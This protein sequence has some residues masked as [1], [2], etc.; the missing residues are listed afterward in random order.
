MF[1]KNID[2]SELSF[3]KAEIIGDKTE[4]ELERNVRLACSSSQQ[5]QKIVCL[6][7][8]QIVKMD[9]ENI[10]TKINTF[11]SSNNKS[12]TIELLKKYNYKTEGYE[13]WNFV[14]PSDISYKSY[15]LSEDELKTAQQIVLVDG[16]QLCGE[17]IDIY[18]YS[19]I[20]TKTSPYI[21]K[22]ITM[23]TSLSPIPD[24]CDGGCDKF[25]TFVN[26]SWTVC[27][28]TKT[29][30]TM[31][32]RDTAIVSAMYE[33]FVNI[34]RD[35]SKFQLPNCLPENKDIITKELQD[36]ECRWDVFNKSNHNFMPKSYIL[37][38]VC[39]LVLIALL[40]R[41]HYFQKRDK[42]GFIK[43]KSFDKFY[44]VGNVTEIHGGSADVMCAWY[45]TGQ[46]PRLF[47]VEIQ[48]V[49]LKQY[50]DYPMGRVD[51]QNEATRIFCRQ[52]GVKLSDRRGGPMELL[53]NWQRMICCRF[54]AGRLE[55]EELDLK[56]TA[57]TAETTVPASTTARMNTHQTTMVVSSRD[58]ATYTMDKDVPSGDSFRESR[59]QR[60]ACHKFKNNYEL[61]KIKLMPTR[62]NEFK[63]EIRILSMV[64]GPTTVNAIGYYRKDGIVLVMEWY[65][66][67]L[68]NVLTREETKLKR[69]HYTEKLL[70]CMV[71]LQSKNP[72]ALDA[73]LSGGLLTTLFTSKSK[74]TQRQWIVH[75]DLHA[76]NVFIDGNDNLRLGDFGNSKIVKNYYECDKDLMCLLSLLESIWQV[77]NYNTIPAAVNWLFSE[78][79]DLVRTL[80]TDLRTGTSK[81]KDG[82]KK[83]NK[84]DKLL[85][86]RD[87]SFVANDTS[88]S[89]D[90]HLET[91]MN[92]ETS[93]SM[94][95]STMGNSVSMANSSIGNSASRDVL[96]SGDFLVSGTDVEL[97]E[98]SS[99]SFRRKIKNVSTS[100]K[101]ELIFKE[102]R[103]LLRD[104]EWKGT[105]V[106]YDRYQRT[107]SRSNNDGLLESETRTRPS[108]SRVM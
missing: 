31:V 25:I 16:V 44:L 100:N 96:A 63:R 106:E 53:F 54:C 71:D 68:E 9:H 7:G 64:Q 91:S 34:I 80:E 10:L 92:L 65:S 107:N 33:P 82:K 46:I 37:Y 81:K 75:G 58:L 67:T 73:K 89:V 24:L 36:I 86:S 11:D 59:N 51:Y 47:N 39:G 22:R 103:R 40:V 87:G 94:E 8:K 102:Y 50:R 57:Y 62:V 28:P 43:F 95:L 101:L 97:S 93:M 84:K 88:I 78:L 56:N 66:S 12:T 45:T 69:F 5:N 42:Y 61:R 15:K 52:P 26:K 48:K 18:G 55:P 14:S 90:D 2:A 108:L 19:N 38:S 70:Y 4:E 76:N 83:K 99:G 49:A 13:I 35:G 105:L 98:L 79:N 74:K 20:N 6:T 27:Q 41:I 21:T 1:F 17:F 72:S 104:P 60:D 30:E 85:T 23:D 32:E 29:C 3:R 77:Y